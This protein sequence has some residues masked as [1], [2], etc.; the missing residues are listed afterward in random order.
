M[1]NI[2]Y[3][4]LAFIFGWL[5][6]DG[7][8]DKEEFFS[9]VADLKMVVLLGLTANTLGM[10]LIICVL[11]VVYGTVYKA[12]VVNVLK[13]KEEKDMAFI[14]VFLFIFITLMIIKYV[15]GVH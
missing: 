1:Q 6:M 4:I 9:G 3:G 2:P 15:S 12:V 10:F 8:A 5:L 7:L 11:T 13:Q 14:P